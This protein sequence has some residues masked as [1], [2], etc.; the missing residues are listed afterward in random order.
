M[1]NGPVKM[2]TFCGGVGGDI[3]KNTTLKVIKREDES[4]SQNCCYLRHHAKGF[5]PLLK[6]NFVP[7]D[8]VNGDISICVNQL[9]KSIEQRT[10]PRTCSAQNAHLKKST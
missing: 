1:R 4:C 10:L 9:Q 2:K 7:V 6:R 8:P 3:Y 5:P